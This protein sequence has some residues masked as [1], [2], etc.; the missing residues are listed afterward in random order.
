MDTTLTV[1]PGSSSKKYG[2]FRGGNQLLVVLF[3]RTGNGY[4]KSIDVKH[5]RTHDEEITAAEY[6]DAL[7]EVVRI[8]MREASIG[9][10]QDIT[11]VGIRVVAPG[12]YFMQH[13][14]IDEGYIDRL[15]TVADAVPLHIPQVIDELHGLAR[16]LPHVPV[17][18]V[19]DSAFHSS[20]PS[21]ARRYSIPTCDAQA[22][23]LYRFGYHGLSVCSVIARA[24]KLLGELPKRAIV[25][26]IGSGVSVTALRDGKSVDTSMGF[27]PTSGLMMGSRVG[28]IDAAAL[29]YLL[30]KKTFTPQE[31]ERYISE[32]GGLKGVLGQSDL[33]I[34]LDR[35]SRGDHE[36]EDAVMMYVYRI[37]KAIGACLVALGGIDTLVLTATA[38]ERN[39]TLRAL[40]C[41]GLEHF[42]ILLNTEANERLVAREGLLS[43]SESRVRVLVIHTNEMSEIARVADATPL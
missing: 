34:A 42:G 22:L 37:K 43:D 6:E 3:E 41:D 29:L 21:Y 17:I 9:S 38:A 19:S 7:D 10:T 30:V 40:I 35:M 23:D 8:A 16:L 5:L 4:R 1:N 39:P 14:R 24:E 33:R 13:R 15:Q 36:A 20:I 2:L 18:G 11:R 27:S 31:A 12:T 26:H 25:V 28:D 32:E